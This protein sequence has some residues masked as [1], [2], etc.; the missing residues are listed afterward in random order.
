MVFFPLADQEALPKTFE[1]AFNAIRSESEA[2]LSPGA[3]GE[4]LDAELAVAIDFLQKADVRATKEPAPALANVSSLA[5]GGLRALVPGERCCEFLT[6]HLPDERLRAAVPRHHDVGARR[7]FWFTAGAVILSTERRSDAAR[8][9]P[10]HTDVHT[11][12]PHSGSQERNLCSLIAELFC[13]RPSE[14]TCRT[15]YH[16]TLAFVPRHQTVPFFR[17]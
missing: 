5:D 16:G 3:S 8:G 10:I 14:V 11:A 15:G 7:A 12:N 17:K 13:Q 6:K 2:I 9:G 4:W 1:E